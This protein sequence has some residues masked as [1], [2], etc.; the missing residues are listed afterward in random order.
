MAGRAVLRDTCK[1]G[2]DLCGN[3]QAAAG[4]TP[5]S[6]RLLEF[7]GG[8]F[9]VVQKFTELTWLI[10]NDIRAGEFDESLFEEQCV[11]C[12]I[13]MCGG[14]LSGNCF[15]V[16]GGEFFQAVKAMFNFH[17]RNGH[18]REFGDFTIVD[19]KLLKQ[20]GI[21]RAR[22]FSGFVQSA[23]VRTG[24]SGF[25]NSGCG[26]GRDQTGRNASDGR[27]GGTAVFAVMAVN[28]NRAFE[29]LD[30]FGQLADSVL[31]DAIVTMRHVDVSKTKLFGELHVGRGTV[32]TDESF[33]AERLQL[34]ESRRTVGQSP[35]DDLGVDAIRIW[36]MVDREFFSRRNW[37]VCCSR[38]IGRTPRNG[39]RARA[40]REQ[41]NDRQQTRCSESSWFHDCPNLSCQMSIPE[42][43]RKKIRIFNNL[44]SE[45]R[46]VVTLRGG[47]PTDPPRDRLPDA[48]FTDKLHPDELGSSTS[49][50]G[51]ETIG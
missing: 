51:V 11:V 40:A 33:H 24:S 26:C 7:R 1:R 32:D 25:E 23:V 5:A 2:T 15:P 46:A 39:R 4:L 48:T 16:R 35:R 36:K 22:G 37:S 29:L 13:V 34:L 6:K 31:G 14:F 3:W 17:H 27:G 20:G 21:Q 30:R 18:R 50:S 42:D 10:A 8:S 47:F 9:A 19:S 12:G 43:Y 49:V 45:F 44:M 41:K 38:R 28:V